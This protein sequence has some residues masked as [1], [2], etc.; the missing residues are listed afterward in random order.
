MTKAEVDVVL[1]RLVTEF[2]VTRLRSVAAQRELLVLVASQT[3]DDK[4]VADAHGYWLE[5]EDHCSAIV[6]RI[7]ELAETCAEGERP[8]PERRYASETAVLECSCHN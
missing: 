7:V 8:R 1:M 3:L 5:L 6:Q 4:T 2:E